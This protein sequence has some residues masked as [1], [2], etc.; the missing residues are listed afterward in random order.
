MNDRENRIRAF[1]FQ[2]PKRIPIASGLPPMCWDYYDPEALEDLYLG[3]PILFPGYKKGSIYPD[4]IYIPPDMH[5]GRPYTDGWG[6]VWETAYTGMVGAV[7]KHALA[8]WSD[9]VSFVPPDPDQHNGMYP[10]NWEEVRKNE[11]TAREKD[12]FF[13]LGLPHGH[14]FLRIQDLRG[15][16][17]LV[18]DMADAHPNLDRLLEMVETFNLALIHRFIEMKPDMILLPEDLGMQTSPMISPNMFRKYIKPVYLKMMQ[19]I[20]EAGIIAHQHS[21][22]YILDLVDDIIN[23]GC[24]VINLQDLVNGIDNIQKHLKGR[25]AIDL[26]IDRQNITNSGSPREIDDLIREEVMKLGSPEGGLSL[27]YQPWPPTPLENIRAV[28]DAMEKYCI[29]YSD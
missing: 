3:H 22:G 5:K 4:N 2:H 24:D 7:K 25:V 17:N 19:P 14:T 1:R 29:Y 16:E 12:Q 26:D 9:F 18:Y 11:R 13:A 20:T 21:D 28:L 27:C 15:Y 6:C 23:C 8:D 10:L